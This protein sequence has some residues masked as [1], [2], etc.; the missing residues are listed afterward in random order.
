MK[1]IKVVNGIESGWVGS[2]SLYRVVRESSYKEVII[3]F[4]LTPQ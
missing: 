2:G 1:N 3:T 4:K